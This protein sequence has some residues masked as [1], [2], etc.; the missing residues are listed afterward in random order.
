MLLFLQGIPPW[1]QKSRLKARVGKNMK[2]WKTAGDTTP[3]QAHVDFGQ[4][5]GAD[6]FAHCLTR[7]EKQSPSSAHKY[8]DDKMQGRKQDTSSSPAV[9]YKASDCRK[10]S[11]L[12]FVNA[13]F[14]ISAGFFWFNV[15]ESH[16]V[17]SILHI[18]QCC[19]P[20]FQLFSF[21]TRHF[22]DALA[23][24]FFFIF[25]VWVCCFFFF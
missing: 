19:F 22:Q 6:P 15:F 3:V 25:V 13:A 24:L 8:I 12:G 11:G 17:Q 1:L 18:H 9:S 23:L 21:L 16:F 7:G 14:P 20:L 4:A 5:L 2:I 10:A